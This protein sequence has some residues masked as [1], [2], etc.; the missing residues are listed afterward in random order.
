MHSFVSNIYLK[1]IHISYHCLCRMNLP[2]TSS[3]ANP[4]Q[5]SFV[6]EQWKETPEMETAMRGNW[7]CLI[8]RESLWQPTVQTG[9]GW[10]LAS[11]RTEQVVLPCTPLPIPC[12]PWFVILDS[13]GATFLHQ[14]GRAGG[15]SSGP[16]GMGLWL[17]WGYGLNDLDCIDWLT[18]TGNLHIPQHHTHIF[19][20]CLKE[21]GTLKV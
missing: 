11:H 1:D 5:Q 13:F 17:E 4:G 7:H 21:K 19:S 9:Q 20:D 14:V 12:I 16:L 2:K 10:H 15:W 6:L 8:S 18:L 3:G